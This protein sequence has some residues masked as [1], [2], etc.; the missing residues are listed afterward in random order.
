M[1]LEKF[2]SEDDQPIYPGAT[3]SY[4]REIPAVD[5]L[6]IPEEIARN[7][8]S[9]AI[10]VR[11]ALAA[12]RFALGEMEVKRRAI[13]FRASVLSSIDPELIASLPAEVQAEVREWASR[14]ER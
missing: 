3:N 9:L 4:L 2:Y 7:P 12:N 14:L 6:G 1:G 8:A 11:D 5:T 13:A 10:Y